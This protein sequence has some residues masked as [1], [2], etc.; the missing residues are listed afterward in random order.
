M[1]YL[2]A[3]L[4]RSKK[5]SALRAFN[6]LQSKRRRRRLFVEQLEDRRLLATFTVINLADSGTGSLRQAIVDANGNSSSDIIQFDSGVNGT[7][8]L[9]T[10]ELAITGA[11]DLQGPGASV[12]AI[13]G[14]NS[15]RIFYVSANATISGLTISGGNSI[16]GGGIFNAYGTLTVVNATLSDN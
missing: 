1:R 8:T 12:L 2:T 14:N 7:I 13:S 4:A 6:V 5:S 11:V 15:S 3:L 16:N 9:T 10:G